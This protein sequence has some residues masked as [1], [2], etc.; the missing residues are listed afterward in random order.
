MKLLVLDNYDSFTYNLIQL[1]EESG[2]LDFDVISNTMIGLE[3]INHYNKILLSPGPGLPKEA[4]LLKSLISVVAGKIP[5]LG[6]CL[7]HQAI[8][9]V[10]GAKLIQCNRIF[11]GEASQV[12]VLD[13]ENYLFKQIPGKFEAG[14]YHSWEVDPCT[15]PESIRITI[16]DSN[17][18]IMGLKHKI[19]DI[20]GL[21]FHPESI[22]TPFGKEIISNWLN[23]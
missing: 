11:H 10:F 17:G 15:L 16:I 20:Q 5:V 19:F 18:S 8:A 6:I 23:H 4:G 3:H 9:E 22:M 12:T 7:G 2:V 1:I 14:R 13:R 21:Q